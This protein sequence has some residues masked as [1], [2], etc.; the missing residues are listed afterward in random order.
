MPDATPT[1]IH[2]RLVTTDG[3]ELAA[4]LATVP[5][6]RGLA[7]LAHPHPSFGGSRRVH[8]IDSWFRALPAAGIITIRFDFRGGGESGGTHTGGELE[9]ID[10][11]AAV[12]ALPETG[13]LP[14]IA[15]G[16]SFGAEILLAHRS[17]HITGWVAVAPP[18]AQR[19]ADTPAGCDDR[20]TLILA[21]EHDQFAPPEVARAAVG[22]WTATAV[23]SIPGTDH[24]LA[25][26]A[27]GV[28]ER[29]LAA[30]DDLT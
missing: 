30:F 14:L 15:A 11:D 19:P 25:G 9:H 10:I 29:T 23:E 7:V 16:W 22:G 12:D 4:D 27:Q 21:P 8:L 28:V 24:S 20:P 1:I 6:P 18:A 3:V 26:A 17:P 2:P 5:D 13:R